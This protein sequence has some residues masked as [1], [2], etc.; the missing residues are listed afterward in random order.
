MRADWSQYFKENDGYQYIEWAIGTEEWETDIL[1]YKYVGNDGSAQV[2]GLDLR[3]LHQCYITV[4]AFK[5]NG[6]CSEVS[7]KAHALR[8]QQCVHSWLVVGDGFVS[9][10]R[11]EC[12][13]TLFDHA[14]DVEEQE[15]KP[16][17]K[18]IQF[19]KYDVSLLKYYYVVSNV[20]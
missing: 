14:E 20:I 2:N 17:K 9:V 15:V 6:R 10:K 12:L 4:R 5:D 11:G 19:G 18:C 1:K 13:R 8:G 16:F 7:V 3:G